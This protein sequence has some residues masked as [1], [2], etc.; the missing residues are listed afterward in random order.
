MRALVA[1][2]YLRIFLLGIGIS[3]NGEP[4]LSGQGSPFATDFDKPDQ[5]YFAF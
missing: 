2:V 5:W 4:Y 3:R 1:S